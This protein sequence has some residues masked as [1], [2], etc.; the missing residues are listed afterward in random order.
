[1]PACDKGASTSRLNL[2]RSCLDE[3]CKTRL[4]GKLKLMSCAR[5]GNRAG[6]LHGIGIDRDRAGA[7]TQLRVSSSLASAAWLR[8]PRHRIPLFPPCIFRRATL[9]SHAFLFAR[10]RGHGEMGAG[11]PGFRC[12]SS[13]L[14]SR[15]IARGAKPSLRA[16]RTDLDHANHCC[17]QWKQWSR[18]PVGYHPD[19][20]PPFKT[21]ASEKPFGS[22]FTP[23]C[24]PPAGSGR[25]AP[26]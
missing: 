22:L 8:R 4:F 10:P 26:I 16:A 13:G 23:C 17:L 12:R 24:H 14:R 19:T 11:S 6:F 25:Q 3:S 18:S 15:S 5:P 2:I 20:T 21:A 7:L 1:M 9:A